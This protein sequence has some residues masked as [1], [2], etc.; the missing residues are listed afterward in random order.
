M[1]A[2]KRYSYQA[3]HR[4]CIRN[5]TM[6]LNQ[7]VQRRMTKSSGNSTFREQPCSFGAEKDGHKDVIKEASKSPFGI[8]TARWINRPFSPGQMCKHLLTVTITSKHTRRGQNSQCLSSS[9]YFLSGHVIEKFFDTLLM[10]FRIGNPNKR[11]FAPRIVGW[12]DPSS[13]RTEGKQFGVS[14]RRRSTGNNKWPSLFANE[15]Q[16]T[17]E[18]AHG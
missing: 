17:S 14:C 7:R 2:H 10:S 11:V 5:N 18:G 13:I 4:L 8:R 12:L 16:D 9:K 1:W 15:A 3:P 6:S